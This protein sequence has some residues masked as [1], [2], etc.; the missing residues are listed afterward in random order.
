MIKTK[1]PVIMVSIP[2]IRRF[3]TFSLNI[4]LEIAIMNNGIEIA[5]KDKL[6]ALVVFPA[7]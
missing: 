1:T 3:E 2:R 4:T 5:I 6:T 7:K